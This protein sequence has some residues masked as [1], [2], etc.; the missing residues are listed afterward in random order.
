MGITLDQ[1]LLRIK[2]IPDINHFLKDA[3]LSSLICIVSF[4]STKMP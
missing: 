4:S 1:V 3:F 2:Y